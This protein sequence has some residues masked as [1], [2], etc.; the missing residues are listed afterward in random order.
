LLTVQPYI[1]LTMRGTLDPV[2]VTIADPTVIANIA[3][4]LRTNGT[5][6]PV[7]SNSRL[8]H[9]LP[10]GG[11]ID[12]SADGLACSCAS[13]YSA[14]PCTGNANWGGVNSTTC[15]GPSQIMIVEFL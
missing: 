8:W 10:C 2:G 6:G 1:A 11:G 3:L 14:R 12:L 5:Y 4:A 15:S 9:V 13:V 7:T